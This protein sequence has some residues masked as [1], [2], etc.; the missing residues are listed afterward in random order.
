VSGAVILGF[1]GVNATLNVVPG[2]KTLSG[3]FQRRK[4]VIAFSSR[5]I[6]A[7]QNLKKEFFK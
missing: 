6:L 3:M 2:V 4:G 7:D 1:R 5:V